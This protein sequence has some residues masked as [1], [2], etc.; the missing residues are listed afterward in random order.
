[1]SRAPH[2]RATDEADYAREHELVDSAADEPFHSSRY[3][4]ANSPES[5]QIADTSPLE[6]C[7]IRDVPVLLMGHPSKIWKRRPRYMAE[8]NE[9]VE[10][11]IGKFLD[12]L[13]TM[14][15]QVNPNLSHHRHGCGRKALGRRSSAEDFESISRARAQKALR[16][17]AARTVAGAYEQDARF[18]RHFPWANSYPG[19]VRTVPVCF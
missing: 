12:R 18:L 9:I 19:N 1:V 10:I 2:A 11:L 13:R 17:L 6:V 14:S 16:H 15:S 7:R 5:L 8:R 3:L 4:I